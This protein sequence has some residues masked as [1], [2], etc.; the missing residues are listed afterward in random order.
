MQVRTV[1]CQVVSDGRLAKK[2]A[3]Q[4]SYNHRVYNLF[5]QLH[6]GFEERP[7]RPDAAS[8]VSLSGGTCDSPFGQV[9]FYVR[10][11]EDDKI[12][13]FLAKKLLTI[14]HL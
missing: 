5:Y 2:A 13:D 1:V 8:K 12:I 9:L 10:I 7:F 4:I 14:T 11:Y 6:S 3:K